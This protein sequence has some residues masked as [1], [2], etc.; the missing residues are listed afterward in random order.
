MPLLGHHVFATRGTNGLSGSPLGDNEVAWLDDTL[1]AE[2]GQ[3]G[4]EFDRLVHDG[5]GNMYYNGG[6]PGIGIEATRL[7]AKKG[8]VIVGSDTL[9]LAV[10]PNSN[11][12]IA[13]PAHQIQLMQNS[14]FMH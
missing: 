5:I 2:I 11:P 8:A 4:T 3:V 9:P 12:R 13:F 6:V 10:V 14:V 7:L 1:T